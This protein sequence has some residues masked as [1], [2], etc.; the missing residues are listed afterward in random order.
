MHL[1]PTAMVLAFDPARYQNQVAQN[2]HF[3]YQEV[4]QDDTYGKSEEYEVGQLSMFLQGHP[5]KK[6]RNL[7]QESET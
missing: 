3:H 7:R 6:N 1:L 5:V 4:H 2:K